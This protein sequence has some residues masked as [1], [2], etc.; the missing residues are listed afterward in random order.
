MGRTLGDEGLD[1]MTAFRPKSV[2]EI[3]GS[4]CLLEHRIVHD[5][6]VYAL[7]THDGDVSVVIPCFEL[8]TVREDTCTSDISTFRMFDGLSG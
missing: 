3:S 6:T 2:S 1:V 5:H 8:E 4:C 7:L